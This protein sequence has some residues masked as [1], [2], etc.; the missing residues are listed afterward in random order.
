MKRMTGLGLTAFALI[1]MTWAGCSS[2]P[3]AATDT[4]SVSVQEIVIEPAINLDLPYEMPPVEEAPASKIDTLISEAE[5]K[6]VVLNLWATWCPPC[7]AEMPYFASFY[8]T[9]NRDKV[10]FIS[11]S[12][13]DISTKDDKVIPFM[14]DL[15]I[16][17]PVYLVDSRDPDDFTAA[18]RTEI[19]G[20]LPATIFYDQQGQVAKLVERDMNLDELREMVAELGGV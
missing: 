5:G 7:V 6:V 10:A 9:M 17:F 3:E 15:R 13:D 1:A 18:L 14:E 8:Q 4:G 2:E 11:V 16:P 20:G 12:A 19:S